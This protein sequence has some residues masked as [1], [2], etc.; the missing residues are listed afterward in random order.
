MLNYPV[1]YFLIALGSAGLAF[2]GV[3]TGSVETVRALFV[4]FLVASLVSMLVPRRPA[5]LVRY[6]D[7]AEDSDELKR[8]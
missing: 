1:I 4:L 5:K 2:S 6:Q 7:S 8:A 3:A